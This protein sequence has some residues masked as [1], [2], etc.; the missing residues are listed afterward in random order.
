[1]SRKNKT[2]IDPNVYKL[3]GPE[4]RTLLF[5][6]RFEC[7]NLYLAQKVS[8]SEYNLLMQND[9]NT[10]GHTQW[11]YFRVANT[12]AGSTVRFTI[13]NYSKPDSLFNYGMKISVY[14]EKKAELKNISW[15]K[16]CSNI[17]YSQ[18]GI[19]RESGF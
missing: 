4:D 3:S 19:K 5:E 9:I 10:Q 16:D 18:N 17:K 1:M 7:G 15:F 14:S 6:S 8:E 2:L 13:L 12:Q 11:F